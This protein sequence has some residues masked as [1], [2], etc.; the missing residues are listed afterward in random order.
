MRKYSVH[1]LAGLTLLSVFLLW[2]GWEF[3]VED[4]IW[5]LFWSDYEGES[6][7]HRWEY[8]ISATI[9]TGIALIIPT[10][11]SLMSI[12]ER[13]Q[14]EE[15]FRHYFDLPLVGSAIYAPDKR[16]IE[17]NDKL[18]DLFGYT[19]DEL[20]ALTWVDITHPDDIAEN[21]RL[22]N[23]ALSGEGDDAYTMDKRF[24]RKDGETIH[25]SISAQCVRRPDGA[26][27]HFIL[28]VQDLTERKR[29]EAALRE[30]EERLRLAG[31]G[32]LSDHP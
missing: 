25:T 5:S 15:R 18:C 26:P 9:F 1:S 10:L 27:D 28:L 17:V 20:M 29:A 24:V 22:F 30:S 14:A 2:V 6:L 11:V 32:R 31:A 3:V 4:V 13:K 19:R 12:T 7:F 16:W 23:R 21:L 8:V